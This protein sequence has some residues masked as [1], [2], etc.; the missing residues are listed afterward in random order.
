MERKT[1]KYLSGSAWH[2]IGRESRAQIRSFNGKPQAT[3]RQLSQFTFLYALKH[4]G[5]HSAMR[6]MTYWLI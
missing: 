1:G 3:A 5:P 6:S 2:D 4:V